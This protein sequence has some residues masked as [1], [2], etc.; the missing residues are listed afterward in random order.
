MKFIKGTKSNPHVST[1]R[2]FLSR[3][4]ICGPDECW[5]WTGSLY[6]L[7]YGKMGL[8]YK[9][10][11]AHRLAYELFIGP[12]PVGQDVCHTCDNRKCCNPGHLFLGTAKDNIED[13]ARKG[14]M[15]R[16]LCPDDV[17]TIRDWYSFGGVTQSEI[18]DRYNISQ[19][20]VWSI[21][22]RRHWKHVA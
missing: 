13:A 2:R 19:A 7:G 11:A 16:K 4:D 5:D 14:R 20:A 18:A 17:R 9:T 8:N 15:T 10:V 22:N 6:R 21:V 1:V 12:I 3:V